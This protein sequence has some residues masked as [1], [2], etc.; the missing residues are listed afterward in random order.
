VRGGD[1]RAGG[2]GRDLLARQPVA[3]P[4]APHRSLSR[5]RLTTQGSVVRG[6]TQAFPPAENMPGPASTAADC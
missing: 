4:S 2:A 6:R 3:A 1:P 5:R